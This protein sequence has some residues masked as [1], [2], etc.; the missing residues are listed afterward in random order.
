MSYPKDVLE[1]AAA[2]LDA[3]LKKSVPEP[4]PADGHTS[5]VSITANTIGTVHTAPV[6]ILE[7]TVRMDGPRSK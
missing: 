3:A 7:Q 5:G 2:A 4:V 1:Q 6:V